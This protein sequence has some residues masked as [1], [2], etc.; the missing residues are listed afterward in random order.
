MVISCDLLHYGIVISV[1]TWKFLSRAAFEPPE[2]VAVFVHQMTSEIQN[3]IWME[4]DGI[5]V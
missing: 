5:P 3:K 2:A 4:D 1:V